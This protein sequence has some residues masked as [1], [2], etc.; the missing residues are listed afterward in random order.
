MNKA[1]GSPNQQQQGGFS[2]LGP[3]F[4]SKYDTLS[5]STQRERRIGDTECLVLKKA[6]AGRSPAHTERK[7]DGGGIGDLV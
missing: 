6:V 4:I 2:A 3:R 7:K 1:V 5:Q